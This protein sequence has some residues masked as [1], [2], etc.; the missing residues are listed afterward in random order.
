MIVHIDI[1]LKFTNLFLLKSGDRIFKACKPRMFKSLRGE[2]WKEMLRRGIHITNR[3]CRINFNYRVRI[4]C[5]EGGKPYNFLLSQFAFRDVL[6]EYHDPFGNWLYAKVKPANCPIRIN[7][8]VFQMDDNPF[9]H[10]AFDF[11]KYMGGFNSR[12]HFHVRITQ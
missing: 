6:R 7:E 10:T 2:A 9:I 12:P 8:P 3:A 1:S 4:P 11:S 5:W